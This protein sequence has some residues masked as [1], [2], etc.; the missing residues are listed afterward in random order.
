V[1]ASRRRCVLDKRPQ[2]FQG[3]GHTVGGIIA[4]PLPDEQSVHAD[5][6]QHQRQDARVSQRLE[7]VRQLRKLG[8]GRHAQPARPE[9][10][11]DGRE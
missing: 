7:Q 2:A 4:V 3:G 9:H 11:T 6:E 10:E 8:V 5:D 1:I